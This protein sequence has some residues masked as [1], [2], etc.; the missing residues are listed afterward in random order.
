[1]I[2][3]SADAITYRVVFSCRILSL[4]ANVRYDIRLELLAGLPFILASFL[5][6]TKLS[7]FDR[8]RFQTLLH[9]KISCERKNIIL[10]TV[11]PN[12]EHINWCLWMTRGINAGE[13]EVRLTSTAQSPYCQP[14]FRY[15][16]S[17][18]LLEISLF[19]FIITTSL[20]AWA[21]FVARY[22]SIRVSN[23]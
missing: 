23:Y 7:N 12:L 10:W 14:R 4:I 9:R 21:T 2:F 8:V 6:R 16:Q 1:M 17:I 19:W 11:E 20:A 15:Q 13:F 22:L 18:K 3:K 5:L